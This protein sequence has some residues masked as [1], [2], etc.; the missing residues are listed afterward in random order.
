MDLYHRVS[1]AYRTG[2]VDVE[3]YEDERTMVVFSVLP[4]VF[5]LHSS[6]VSAERDWYVQSSTGAQLADLGVNDHAVEVTDFRRIID[7][8]ERYR[9]AR[10]GIV[11]NRDASQHAATRNGFGL[12]YVARSQPCL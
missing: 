10:Q 11:M 8:G 3:S 12:P 2:G 7:L 9:C 6:H 5:A 1:D 4:D